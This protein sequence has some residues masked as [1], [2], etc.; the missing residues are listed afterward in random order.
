MH[1]PGLD[2]K[3]AVL[4]YVLTAFDTLEKEMVK[5]K[6]RPPS[7]AEFLDAVRACLKLNPKEQAE[8]A[9]FTMQ[10]I[11]EVQEAEE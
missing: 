11:I 9:R 7:T 6:R 10:K 4:G 2:E 1:N 8:M 5:Q 3:A